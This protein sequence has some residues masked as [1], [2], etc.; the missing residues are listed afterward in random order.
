MAVLVTIMRVIPVIDVRH[1][2]AVHAR[3]GRR[4]EYRPL[5]SV[6]CEGCDPTAIAKA[7]HTLGF[8]DAYL[9]DLDAIMDGTPN[10]SLY[11]R[12]AQGEELSL[13]VD[14]GVNSIEKATQILK[15]GV[16]K[17]IVGTETL[18]TSEL[19]SHV[20]QHFPARV[21]VSLDLISG[22]LLT[23]VHELIGLSVVEAAVHF[24]R[25]GVTELIVL[26]LA[27]IG[28]GLGPDFKLLKDVRERCKFNLLVGGGVRSLADLE[29]LRSIGANAALIATTLHSG[30]ISFDQLR[31]AHFL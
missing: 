13:M 20:L 1:G 15:S 30:A 2:I 23:Q 18:T 10:L 8:K 5:R 21:V 6:L 22:R 31:A 14:A 24:Q 29:Q 3:Q 11:Q 25:C 16:S 28:S 26:D 4:A 19:I 7:F 27:R 12:I 17:V 9:A